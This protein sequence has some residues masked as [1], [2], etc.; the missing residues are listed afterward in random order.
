MTA[1]TVNVTCTAHDQNGNPVAGARF[2]A[3]LDRTEIYGGFVVPEQFTGVAN[4]DGV[5]VLQLWPNALGVASSQYKISAVNPDD[6][7][8]FLNS[9]ATIPNNDCNLHEVMTLE[10]YPPINAAQQALVAAQNAL[11]PVQEAATEAL[12]YRDNALNSMNT[13]VAAASAAV[14]SADQANIDASAAASS[15]GAASS[16]ALTASNAASDAASSASAAANAVSG[17]AADLAAPTGS[18]LVGSDDGAGGSLWTTVAGFIARTEGERSGINLLRYIPP[19]QWPA[20]IEGTSTYD[21]SADVQAAMDAAGA[22][23]RPLQVVGLV[24][25]QPN[26][27]IKHSGLTIWSQ[28]KHTNGF[29]L[30]VKDAGVVDFYQAY[31][32]KENTATSLRDIAFYNLGF[33]CNYDSTAFTGK[34]PIAAIRM[35]A[36]GGAADRN[37]T[38]QNCHFQNPQL[39]CVVVSPDAN[40]NHS[41]VFVINCTADVDNLATSN[42]AANLVRTIVDYVGA[43]S[44]ATTYGQKRITNI[45]VLGG[46]A[47]G[48]RTFADL[49][50]GSSNYLVQGCTTEDMSDCHHSVDGGSKGFLGGLVGRQKSALLPTKNFVEIQGEDI[51]ADGLTYDGDKTLGGMA[52]VLV[53]DYA[54]PAEGAGAAHQSKGVTVRNVVIDGVDSHAV[55]LQNTR[56][57]TVDN[58]TARNCRLDAAAIEYIADK[59]DP[60]AGALSPVGNVVDKVYFDSTVR[61]GVNAPTV[62][63]G[64]KIGAVFS[65]S[66]ARKVEGAN[67]NTWAPLYGVDY[68]EQN[69]LMLMD[70]AGTLPVGFKRSS[71]SV[72]I[73][74]ET[75]DVPVEYGIAVTVNGA[76]AAVLDSIEPFQR[77]QVSRG[78]IVQLDLHAKLNTAAACGVLLQEFNGA[79]FLS[80][81]FFAL[82]AVSSSWTKNTVRMPCNTAGVN[83][84]R[85]QLLPN[86][87][88]NNAA[89]VGI[90]RFAGVRFGKAQV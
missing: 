68:T 29:D 45:Q 1:P 80:S 78:E 31:F 50:R 19:D 35:R 14:A 11:A 82:S 23:K 90:S 49:K 43:P 84:V 89:A 38:V 59:T 52:G 30:I 37:L 63:S 58:I 87:S 83:Q 54:D 41:G 47:R 85:I 3:R 21:A 56:D 64:N 57:C 34:D 16:S 24:R 32:K 40:S 36:T 86:A 74:Q 27:L 88:T 55:R 17:F 48:I 79:T 69:L 6:G 28:S 72:T 60:V 15:A 53:Q 39:D 70:A 18:A 4:A 20:I 25:I 77:L 51:V 42:R 76:D 67:L 61:Y 62:G 75:S 71:A 65:A 81:N 26:R 46:A 33:R 8:R 2:V 22:A 5:C 66:G 73:S 9:L 7:R 12:G 13:A 44:M 10:P